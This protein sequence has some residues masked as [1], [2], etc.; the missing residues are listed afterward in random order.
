MIRS[1]GQRQRATQP[2]SLL[3]GKTTPTRGAEPVR[4]GRA[5]RPLSLGVTLG[6]PF[7]LAILA[8]SAVAS[9]VPQI[10]LRAPFTHAV[11]YIV[12]GG[13]SGG[14]GIGCGWEKRNPLPHWSNVSGRGG[15]GDFASGRPCARSLGI[16]NNV[17][18][19]GAESQ[20]QV[21]I[22]MPSNLSGVRH[23]HVD[24]V[25]LA[26]VAFSLVV[27]ACRV[28]NA[29]AAYCV[30]LAGASLVINTTL[31]DFTNRTWADATS[32]W[33]HHEFLQAITDCTAG[34]CQNWTGTSGWGQALGP[35][36]LDITT[37]FVRSHTY[38]LQIGVVGQAVVFFSHYH[39]TIFG[40]FATARLDTSTY[41]TGITLKS[42]TIR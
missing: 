27:G 17:T 36:S 4:R 24:L 14:A 2:L 12:Q 13:R 9:P 38:L 39:A 32:D 35:L 11:L 28:H 37:S 42:I 3:V 1:N 19:S 31:E 5:A 26:T 21:V 29:S 40:G 16:A 20:Y 18:S 30:Q 41:S 15:F 22:T 23:I 8:S 33:Q 34:R 7:V 10:V 6:V 25:A